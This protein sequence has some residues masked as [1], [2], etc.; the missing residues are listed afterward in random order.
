LYCH[1]GNLHDCL[2]KQKK[3]IILNF[4]LLGLEL[5]NQYQ[6]LHKDIEHLKEWKKNFVD[7]REALLLTT[8]QLNFRQKQLISE[9]NLI[10]PIV[11]VN[12]FL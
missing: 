7:M 8:A 12:A 9:L 2:P 10:Y 3:S 6:H 4:I 5:L 1:D 11:Q